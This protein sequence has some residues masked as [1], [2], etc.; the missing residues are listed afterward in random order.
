MSDTVMASV[1]GGLMIDAP[2]PLDSIMDHLRTVLDESVKRLRGEDRVLEVGGQV[3]TFPGRVSRRSCNCEGECSHVIESYVVYVSMK[4]ITDRED[5]ADLARVAVTQA[6]GSARATFPN[7]E[8]YKEEDEDEDWLRVE[9][10][11][12]VTVFGVLVFDATIPLNPVLD[13]LKGAYS[14]SLKAVPGEDRARIIHPCVYA[15]DREGNEPH[16][17]TLGVDAV[18]GSDDPVRAVVTA[19]GV[20]HQTVESLELIF[21]EI[22]F[23]IG[24]GTKAIYGFGPHTRWVI[25]CATCGSLSEFTLMEALDL[26]AARA[27]Q[28]LHVELN[29]DHSVRVGCRLEDDGSAR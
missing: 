13:Q 3:E 28:R 10:G 26:D 24:D 4:I 2:A 8:F 25:T 21:P 6:M 1:D 16:H 19:L 15:H 14:D 17:V 22:D 12:L 11:P 23:G 27:T 5:T 20:V 9:A 7:V 29:P 18:T